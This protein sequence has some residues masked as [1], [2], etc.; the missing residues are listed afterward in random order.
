MEVLI[1]IIFMASAALLG[2]AFAINYF[3]QTGMKAAFGYAGFFVA[4]I[5]IFGASGIWINASRHSWGVLA[6][7]FALILGAG[8][9]CLKLVPRLLDAWKKYQSGNRDK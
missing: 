1:A 8:W 3:W 4:I 6:P 2:L 9:L 7:V 5:F